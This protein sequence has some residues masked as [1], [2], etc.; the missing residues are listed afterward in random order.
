MKLKRLCSVTPGPSSGSSVH[1]TVWE[2]QTVNCPPDRNVLNTLKD[3]DL[4]AIGQLI[5]FTW[6]N[7]IRV[8]PSTFLKYPGWNFT[9]TMYLLN[10]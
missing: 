4:K 8:R 9:L 3:K 10:F 6:C 5:A 1:I 2:L 7:R